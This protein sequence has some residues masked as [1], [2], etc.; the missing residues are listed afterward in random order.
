MMS[1]EYEMDEG[2]SNEST[3]AQQNVNIEWNSIQ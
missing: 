3:T 1:R 2:Q